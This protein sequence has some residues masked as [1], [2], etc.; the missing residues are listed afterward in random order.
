MHCSKCVSFWDSSYSRP[1]THT[2][3][4]LLLTSPLLQNPGGAIGL[5]WGTGCSTSC[6]QRSIVVCSTQH[7]STWRTAASTPQTLLVASICR[8]ADNTLSQ[9][10]TDCCMHTSAIAHRQHLRSAGCHQLFVPR[11]RRSM[12]WGRRKFWKIDYDIELNGAFWS[13]SEQ[14]CD[15]HSAVLYTCLLWLLSKYNIKIENCCF[16]CFRFLIFHPFF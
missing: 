3:L 9:Y 16:A 11:H 2:S 8:V 7:H 13:I 14:I 4:P 1:P 6:A 12:F 10:M 5:G 15:Q